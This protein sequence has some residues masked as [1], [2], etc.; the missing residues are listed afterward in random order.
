MSAMYEI[1]ERDA[2]VQ[3]REFPQC[4]P[5]SSEPTVVATVD[6][7]RLTYL[8]RI[9]TTPDA[10]GLAVVS[11]SE[12][13][14]HIFCSRN[15]RAHN[16]HPLF[17]RGLHLYGAYRVEHSSWV[18]AYARMSGI[19]STAVW[20]DGPPVH[21]VFTFHDAVFE[22]FAHGHEIEVQPDGDDALPSDSPTS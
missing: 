12:S 8:C 17:E 21:Y 11:F 3:L 16:L 18:R 5:G 19:G 7:L 6:S 10:L 15:W 4:E 22:C 14:Q 20:L 13:S 1:D 2:V 9:D